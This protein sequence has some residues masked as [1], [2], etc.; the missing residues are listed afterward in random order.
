MLLKDFE[1]LCFMSL[2][3]LLTVSLTPSFFPIFKFIYLYIYL[4][5]LGVSLSKWDL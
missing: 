2:N 4:A 5:A 1:K 3:M